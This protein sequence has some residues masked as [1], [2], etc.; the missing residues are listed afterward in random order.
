MKL[1]TASGGVSSGIPPKPTRLRSRS[2][3]A[4]HLAILSG[5]SPACRTKAYHPCGKPQGILAKANEKSEQ[6][7][8]HLFAQVLSVSQ[9]MKKVGSGGKII[10]IIEKIAGCII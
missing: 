8:E 6:D 4:V 5:R 7:D 2:Y 10:Y 3:G 1:P 9:I